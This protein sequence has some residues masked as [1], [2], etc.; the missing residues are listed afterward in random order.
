MALTPEEVRQIA[1]LARLKL[2]AEEEKRYAEQLSAVLDYAARLSDVDT[3]KI[4]P[5]ATVLPLTAPLRKDEVVPCLPREKILA[6]APS[7]EE[8]MFSVPPVLD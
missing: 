7:S 8:G 1:N 5:T 4:P 2:T 3:S 6:N